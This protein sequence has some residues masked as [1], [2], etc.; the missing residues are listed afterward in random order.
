MLAGVIEGVF[1][2]FHHQIDTADF[3][4]ATQTAFGGQAP[5]LVEQVF[6]KFF[7]FFQRIKTLSH[8]H[9]TGGASAGFFASVVDVD[10]VVQQ[11]IANGLAFGGIGNG[12]AF[13][14]KGFMG[15]NGN[16]WH[17]GICVFVC[18]K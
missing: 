2:D 7:G 13:G 4:L 3:G 5:C 9:M 10:A 17:D 18:V 1:G 12:F 16:G 8:N 6:F 14:A 11:Q 15:Q